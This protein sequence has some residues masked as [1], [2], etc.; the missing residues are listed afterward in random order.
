MVKYKYMNL[1][2]RIKIKEMLDAEHGI[3]EIANELGYSHVTIYKELERCGLPEEYNPYYAQSLCEKNLKKRGRIDKLS[4]VELAKYISDLIL[5]EHL[6][7]EKIVALLKKDSRGFPNVPHSAKTIYS[8]IDKGLIPNVTR[9]IF[10]KDA[11]T[12]FSGGQVCIPKWVLDK[13]NIKDGD[14]L[15]LEVTKDNEI[16]YKKVD[17]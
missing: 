6:S 15:S 4:D 17:K 11:S 1:E 16:I 9:E 13:L 14:E 10:L 5:K 12:V 3:S 7:P 2:Q 8:A